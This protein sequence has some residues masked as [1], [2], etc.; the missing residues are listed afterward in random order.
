MTKLEGK[1]IQV[2]EGAHGPFG[3]F[4]TDPN[5]PEIRELV[6]PE[7]GFPTSEAAVD[8]IDGLLAGRKVPYLGMEFEVLQIA[9]PFSF[10]AFCSWED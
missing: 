4:V 3:I 10:K 1:P 6:V 9:T 5:D 8:Y 2:T 7:G